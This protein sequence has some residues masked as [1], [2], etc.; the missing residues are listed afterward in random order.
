[1][2]II[3]N[4][5]ATY[6]AGAAGGNRE[7]L[8]DVIYNISPTE[9]PFQ[10]NIAKNKATAITH[11]WQT[12]S[13]AAAGANAVV[14]GD[15]TTVSY[16]F[17]AVTAT[18]RLA[19]TCQISRKD[20]VVAGTQDAVNKA[21]REREIVYQLVKRSKELRRDMEFIL[22]NNQTPVTTGA[23]AT[24]RVLRPVVGWYSTNVQAN[25]GSN[26][27]TTAARVDGTQRAATE[28]LAKAAIQA[29]WTQGGDPDLIMVGPFNKTVVSAWTGN[30]TRMQDTSNGKLIAAISV[31]ESDFGRHKI[32]ANRFSRERDMHILTTDLWAVSYLRPIRT[33]DL[34]KTGD[35]EKGMIIA[36]YTLESRNQAGSALV[37][38]LTTQ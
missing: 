7:D 13:L 19:N 11:E 36:E 8:S 10:A 14:E 18:S 26:G 25:G 6:G 22:T 3:T 34:A 4:T 15:D 27:T 38:D 21:G 17:A 5:F 28:S 1:M 2:A 20:V 37:A 32:V 33:I 30:N 9:F 12:D 35:N 23:A 24:A 16:T 29:A 31:Y